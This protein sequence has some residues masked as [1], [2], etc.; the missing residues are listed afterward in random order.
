MAWMV[1]TSTIVHGV[2]VPSFLLGSAL[3]PALHPKWLVNNEGSGDDESEESD[4]EQPETTE[5]HGLLAPLVH[6]LQRYGAMSGDDYKRED[7]EKGHPISR[8]EL[9]RVLHNMAGEANEESS[10]TKGRSKGKLNDRQKEILLGEGTGLDWTGKDVQVYDEGSTLIITDETGKTAV[11]CEDIRVSNIG[12]L[13][14]QSI[15]PQDRQ[16]NQ[17]EP[18]QKRGLINRPPGVPDGPTSCLRNTKLA[19]LIVYQHCIRLT[20]CM[21]PLTD[22][23]HI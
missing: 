20:L 12:H 7:G 10:T 3:H 21:Y 17:E 9:H 6:T 19:G 8:D 16:A 11:T 15:V 22:Q 2:T 23:Y 4:G 13:Y 14:R 18:G 1:F 5:R